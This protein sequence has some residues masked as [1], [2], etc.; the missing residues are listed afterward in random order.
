[1]KRFLIV[2]LCM[3]ILF[4]TFSGCTGNNNQT[5]E[6]VNTEDTTEAVTTDPYNDDI[7]DTL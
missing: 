2:L 3:V 1:M 5:G 7:P 6:A 4:L